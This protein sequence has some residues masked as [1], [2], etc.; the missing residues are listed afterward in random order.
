MLNSNNSQCQLYRGGP[1]LRHGPANR[2]KGH[3]EPPQPNEFKD[4]GV[5]QD[6]QRIAGLYTA[7]SHANKAIVHSTEEA[8]LYHE[9]CRVCAEFIHLDLAFISRLDDTHDDIEVV[10]ASG[11]LV[12]YLGGI[13]IRVHPDG[14]A[15]GDLAGHCLAG[16]GEQICQDWGLDPR[17]TL[18]RE[19]AQAFGVRSSA[20]FPLLCEERVVS[21][22]NLYSADRGFFSTDRL[23]LLREIA[24]DTSFA[25]DRFA[26]EAH[27]QEAEEAFRATFEQAAVGITHVSLEG[28]LLKVNRRFSEMLGYA[29]DD[30]AGRLDQELTAPE[31]RAEDALE[32][33]A[34]VTG[35]R[36][37]SCWEKR[38]LAKA[39]EPV[40]VRVTLALLHDLAGA[41]TYFVNVVEDLTSQKQASAEHQDLVD[42]LHQARKM[43][44]LG[45]LS[46][47][48][49]HDINNILAA[50]LGIAEVLQV[51][52][53][54]AKGVAGYLASI[55]R[56]S[57]RGRD[58]VKNLTAFARKGLKEAKLLDL[59]QLV[60]DE[61]ELL[62]RTTLQRV[63]VRSELAPRLQPIMGEPSGIAS[64]LMNLCVNAVNAM[65]EGGILTIR[66]VQLPDHWV[67]LVVTDT[68]QGMGPEVLAKAVEPF[69]TTQP[70][71]KGTGLGLT[72]A[73]AVLKAHG[74][75]LA[76][77]SDLGKGT[78][79]SM[80]F[81]GADGAADPAEAHPSEQAALH[82]AKVLIVDDDDLFLDIIPQLLNTMGHTTEI[83]HGGQEALD[84]LEGG[85]TV[86]LVILDQNM[87]GLSGTETLKRIRERWPLL[88]VIIGTGYL[89]AAGAAQAAGQGRVRILHKPYT[90]QEIRVAI[91]EI[92][93]PAGAPVV[94]PKGL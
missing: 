62:C 68:G 59:N 17:M 9:V 26:R 56:A 12:G 1:D 90:S 31:D 46:A 76:I 8:G 13:S 19:R 4:Q 35:T 2:R 78:T 84:L 80:R 39:G 30:V 3:A 92:Q 29:E 32:I 73:F 81:P 79:V 25:L 74:G 18:W 28:R 36:P 60:R 11:R 65:P 86:D 93:A 48:I 51:V 91:D 58:L 5:D 57:E 54:P 24:G 77:T 10:V 71:G 82:P 89:D 33:Q 21:V 70:V 66:T 75:T 42:N 47:G 67:E 37:S 52:C 83:A 14:T 53:D 38:Y 55:V 43:E 23:D 87:P 41:P 72:I 88:P 94:A 61:I 85:L 63:E 22:L 64:A 16:M 50:I 7:L 45:T 6:R 34:L 40:W 49:A 69:F 27:R 15:G 20:C 44:S